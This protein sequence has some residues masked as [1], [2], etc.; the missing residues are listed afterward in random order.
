MGEAASGDGE[1][2]YFTTYDGQSGFP[3]LDVS[4]VYYV[5]GL[6]MKPL[7]PGGSTYV[8][9]YVVVDH[10]DNMYEYGEL[11]VSL[12]N[13]DTNSNGCPDF[14]EKGLS[15]SVPFTGQTTP[16]WNGYGIYL[17]STVTGS[18]NRSADHNTGS[19]TGSLVNQQVTTEFIGTWNILGGSGTVT[20]QPGTQSLEIQIALS[21]FEETNQFSGTATIVGQGKDQILINSFTL[22]DPANELSI[23]AYSKTLQRSGKYYRGNLEVDD[24]NKGTSWRDYYLYRIEIYD[25]NDWNNDG[26]P[27]LTDP[28]P[29]GVFTK[30]MPWLPLLL[31][32]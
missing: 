7:T 10:S 13:Q 30:S 4:G 14:L 31:D 6:E 9:D 3:L 29:A 18:L 32:D 22:T 26:V 23:T 27:D 11:S 24:G 16:H 2:I 5:V 21:A 20:Y 25:E 28:K 12:S 19:Y 8:A 17:N 1:T 15:A